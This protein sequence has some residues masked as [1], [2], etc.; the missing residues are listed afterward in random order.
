MT[1]TLLADITSVADSLE[2]T[3]AEVKKRQLPEALRWWKLVAERYDELDAQRK[4][5]NAVLENLS[6]V[7]LPEMM[8]EAGVKTVTV[9]NLNGANYRFTVSQRFSCSMPDKEQ[10]MN[11]L[12][13]N[14]LG[15]LIQETVN[16][17]TLSSAIKKM[18]EDEGR[19]PPEDL[20]KQ[21]YMNYTSA[22]KAR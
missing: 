15:D 6:R 4:R 13:E 22:T 5:I 1:D 8:Q 2:A 16:A 19:E 9:E 10:G 18:I 20:F 7:T 21:S 3:A 12:R 14:N 17:Q 11:W